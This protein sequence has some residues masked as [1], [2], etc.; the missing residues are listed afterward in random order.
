[1]ALAQQQ[2]QFKVKANNNP[3]AVPSALRQYQGLM[4][5]QHS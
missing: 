4:Q 2:Q 1:M 3:T 5:Q